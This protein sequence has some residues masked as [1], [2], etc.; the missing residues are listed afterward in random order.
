MYA[1]PP[2]VAVSC[3]VNMIPANGHAK[4]M[5][6]CMRISMWFLREVKRASVKHKEW[7]HKRSRRL[8]HVD[9]ASNASPCK[10]AS[11]CYPF[12]SPSSTR[13]KVF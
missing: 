5:L 2:P 8:C 10:V 12:L 13:M 4:H 6:Q 3:G 7:L 1:L 9:D 11:R